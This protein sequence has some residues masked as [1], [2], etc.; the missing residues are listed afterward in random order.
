M[1]DDAGKFLI[2][3]GYAAILVALVRPNSLGPG[4]VTSVG[5][6]M[7]KLVGSSVGGGSW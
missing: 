7:A 3:T 4:L 6:G 5:G 2:L 1:S